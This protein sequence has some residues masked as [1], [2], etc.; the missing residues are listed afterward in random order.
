MKRIRHFI[1]ALPLLLIACS[2][3]RGQDTIGK[4]RAMHIE[5]KEEKIENG[6]EKAM[7]R[8]QRFLE[9]TPDSTLTPEAT[10]RLADLK[11][12]KEYGTLTH[13][14]GSTEGT[15]TSSAP[16]HATRPEVMSS[17]TDTSS[18]RHIPVYDESEADFEKRTTKRQSVESTAAASDKPIEG[19]DDLERVG[20]REAIAFTKSFLTIIPST[21]VTTKYCTRCLAHM[22]SWDRSRKPWRSWTG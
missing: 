6:L 8:Y 4:L 17:V 15:P 7:A 22:R 2:S 9:E 11:I 16:K 1:W 20:T 10:R 18:D 3:I 21:N 5:I 14:A 13:H 12:E 19:V